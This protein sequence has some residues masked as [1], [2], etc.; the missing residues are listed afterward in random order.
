MVVLFLEK[1]AQSSYSN[2]DWGLLIN[3]TVNCV[4]C[5]VLC[6][7]LESAGFTM[8]VCGKY[9]LHLCVLKALNNNR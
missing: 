6:V 3:Y 9:C 4:C 5:V 8:C 2:L 1:Y 7:C